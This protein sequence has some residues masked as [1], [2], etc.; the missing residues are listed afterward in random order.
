MTQGHKDALVKKCSKYKETDMPIFP[1]SPEKGERTPAL[2]NTVT[3]SLVSGSCDEQQADHA[4]RSV[5]TMEIESSKDGE[6][7]KLSSTFSK[8]SKAQLE[9]H[10][11]W[12]AAAEAAVGPGARIVL[13]KPV[14]K[15]LIYDFLYDSF[16]PMNITEI[17]KVG[18]IYITVQCDC[19]LSIFLFWY[20]SVSLCRVSRLLFLARS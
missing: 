20:H 2:T 3:P 15:Q 7:K 6:T 18:C 16:R 17:H 10:R 5:A 13:S 11:K 8:P 9:I 4:D 1:E 14:A 12:Q 19:T